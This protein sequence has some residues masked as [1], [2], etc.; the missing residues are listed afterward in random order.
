MLIFGRVSHAELWAASR[1]RGTSS[2]RCT[3]GSSSCTGTTLTGCCPGGTPP[4]Y[5]T[6]LEPTIRSPTVAM[7]PPPKNQ[8][9]QLECF[10]HEYFHQSIFLWKLFFGIRSPALTPAIA[11]EWSL[12]FQV[13]AL[14]ALLFVQHPTPP[15]WLPSKYN[16][17]AQFCFAALMYYMPTELSSLV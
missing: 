14:V 17:Q 12:L 5:G 16:A 7:Q 2:S 3:S 4:R 10:C 9:G 1:A 11:V 8:K 6:C 15:P 13:A